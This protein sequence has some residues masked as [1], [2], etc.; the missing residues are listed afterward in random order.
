MAITYSLAPNP[1]WYIADL[2]G[3]PL[4]G[5]YLATFS[6]LD[7]TLLNPVFQDAGGLFP[8]P[9]VTIPNVGSL[10]ILFD[11]NGAQGPF[12]FKFDSAIPDQLYYLEVYDSD[13]VLQWTIDDF[14][15][16]TGGGGTVITA[17]DIENLVANNV[18]WRNMIG[19][20][21]VST[22]VKVKIAPGANA[23]LADTASNAGPDIY[24]LKNNASATDT[25]SFPKF[26]L[27][28]TPFTGDVTPVDYLHYVCS[29]AGAAET[30]KL[31]QFPITQ[32]VQN[33]SNQNMTVTIWARATA[34]NTTLTLGWRQFFGDGAGASP[35]VL[36]PI[37]TLTLTASWQKFSVQTTIPSVSGKVLGGC[38]NDGLFLQVQY[39]L[40]ATCTTDFTKPS[41]YLG[42]ISPDEDYHTYDQIDALINT[43]RT[44]FITQ[45]YQSPFIGGWILMNDGSIG[46]AS[47]LATNRANID[48][49]PLFNLL[50][51]NVIDT[52]APVSGGRTGDAIADFTAGKTM[53]LPN[54]LGR[55]L[56]TSGSGAG[57]TPR[58]AGEVLGTETH[59]LLG[60]EL[61]PSI[62]TSNTVPIS[63][64]GASN[65][66]IGA[67]NGNNARGT[68]TVTT[69]LGGSGTAFSIMQPSSFIPMYIKL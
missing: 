22:S 37:Q 39:P 38:G 3:R 12:Y 15:A 11:E 33:L 24:F 16:G 23:A 68:F 25:I 47:S 31:V 20:T 45:G 28:D 40:D 7:H 54:Q 61:P 6:S 30:S 2:V 59:M 43:P 13:G 62:L 10:G 32:A 14:T 66:S 4:G 69:S 53:T 51:N 67:G 19:I 18:M 36:T 8:W 5:G 55:V 17:L 49:F 26:I 50:Y 46:N 29:V 56:G 60:P 35:D 65:G 44:G 42:N 41:A 57:L 64:T 21:P 52:W 27:G 48:T 63:D 34:G 9:Y 58:A 1:K